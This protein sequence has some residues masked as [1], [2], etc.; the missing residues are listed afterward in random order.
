MLRFLSFVAVLGILYSIYRIIMAVGDPAIPEKD[1]VVSGSGK[2]LKIEHQ[3]QDFGSA[4]LA[5]MPYAKR[6]RVY[7]FTGRSW[8]PTCRAMDA[9]ILAS[10]EWKSLSLYQ[11]VYKEI[12]LPQN[13][14]QA[15]KINRDLVSKFGIQS[16]PTLVVVSPSGSELGRRPGSGTSPEQLVTWVREI[17]GIRF[18]PQVTAGL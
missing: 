14:S 6:P 10:S 5:S 16:V 4:G 2:S 11:V 18:R 9:K 13:F 8:S 1:A 3:S 7:L 15:S 12:V 17:A